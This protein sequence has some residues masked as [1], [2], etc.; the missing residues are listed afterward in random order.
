MFENNTIKLKVTDIKRIKT[1]YDG[2]YGEAR[3]YSTTARTYVAAVAIKDIPASLENWRKVNVRDPLM[4]SAVAK[5]ILTSLQENPEAF[6][7]KNR[8][9]TIIAD[10]INLNKNDDYIELV[11]GDSQLSGLLDGGHTYKAI[12]T[13]IESLEEDESS[14]LDG[15]VKVEIIVGL[16][17]ADDIVAVVEARNTSTQVKEESLQELAN[18]FDHIKKVL[19]DQT[20]FK[21]IAFKEVEL[22]E[23]GSRKDIDIKDILS[24]LLCF[25]AERFPMESKEQPTLAYSSKSAVVKYFKDDDNRLRLDKYIKLLP[26]ILQLRDLIYAELPVVYNSLGGH[27][28]MLTGVTKTPHKGEPVQL[29]FTDLTT[30]VQIPSSFIYPILASFRSLVQVEAGEVSWVADPIEVWGNH[31]KKLADSIGLAAKQLQN[32]NKMGKQKSLWE[33][34]YRDLLVARLTQQL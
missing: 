13:Y 30:A 12:R 24:Y 3:S 15:H 22:A 29:P 9:I 18:H 34:C 32:P 10:D 4:S 20:Y 25:D 11:F 2:T 21:N 6:F 7:F 16:K 1:P 5:G 33:T 31:K 14:G 8:G 19:E 28:S 26:E 27:F 23:D 17:S